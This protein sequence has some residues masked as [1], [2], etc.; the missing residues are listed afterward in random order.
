MLEKKLINIR[1]SR[2]AIDLPDVVWPAAAK[3]HPTC[4]VPPGSTCLQ[5]ERERR[6][7]ARKA[8]RRERRAEPSNAAPRAKRAARL[9]PPLFSMIF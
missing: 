2:S 3:R 4:L 8:K 7:K 5:Q 1:I 9:L 6:R